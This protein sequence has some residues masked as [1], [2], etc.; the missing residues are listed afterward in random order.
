MNGDTY[1]SRGEFLL[2]SQVGQANTA[3]GIPDA[4]GTILY[5][6]RNFH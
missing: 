2:L 1:S 6:L 5:V 4:R 3:Q